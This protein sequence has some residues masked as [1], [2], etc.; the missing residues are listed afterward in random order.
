MTTA[1]ASPVAVAAPAC[2]GAFSIDLEDFSQLT[3]RDATG[4]TP[5]CSPDI[6]RQVDA[7]L[8][9]LSEHGVRGTFFS[10]GML[11]S[12]RPDIIR[13]IQRCGHEMASHGTAHVAASR[14]SRAEFKA[15]VEDSLKLL[16]DITGE[17]VLGYRA[18]AFSIG[19]ANLWALDVLAELGLMY[20][21]SVFPMRMRRYGIDGFDPSP[22]HYS[23]PEGGRLV[24]IPLLPWRRGSR[25]VP[26]AGGGYLRLMP[27]RTL[28]SAVES[29]GRAGQCYTLYLHPY[30]FDPRPLDVARSFP[31]D[32]PMPAL[33]RGL[34][35]AKWNLRRSTIVDKV[36][37]LCRNV[38]FGTYADL[39]QRIQGMPAAKL[40][41]AWPS[42]ARP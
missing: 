22:R 16:A 7:I 35:N 5:D 30:E 6:D 10:L 2:A 37:R 33:K 21:S 8:S 15:D 3:C 29:F 39:A 38:R 27:R 19:R 42:E 34:L 17:R 24:E 4:I 13:R 36:R 18:P 40:G 25:N 31:S 12:R 1:T 11:G 23:L 9:I 32:R 14:Q 20:D 26:V 41:V 28:R